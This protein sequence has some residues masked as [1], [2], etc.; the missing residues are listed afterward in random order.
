MEVPL[1]GAWESGL[2]TC[3]GLCLIVIFEMRFFLKMMVFL[4]PILAPSGLVADETIY[5]WGALDSEK[6][7]RAV[8]EKE[9]PKLEFGFYHWS[10]SWLIGVLEDFDQDRILLLLPSYGFGAGKILRNGEELVLPLTQPV[11]VKVAGALFSPEGM[12][13]SVEDAI[14]HRLGY[15]IAL[16]ATDRLSISAETFSPSEGQFQATYD[17]GRG[18]GSSFDWKGKRAPERRADAYEI[19]RKSLVKRVTGVLAQQE[20][21]L[22]R[23]EDGGEMTATRFSKA[24]D[25][26]ALTVRLEVS[27]KVVLIGES[28]VR[29]KLVG[30]EVGGRLEL[31]IAVANVAGVLSQV[32]MEVTDETDDGIFRA[33][34]KAA[35]GAG[36]V[37]VEI[38]EGE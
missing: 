21:C 29:E 17:P 2:L 11:T 7:Y 38:L 14:D 23:F 13:E 22:I 3:Y 37:R 27:D 24:G 28:G 12:T 10:G 26:D 32:V 20:K 19:S 1:W 33:A 4:A 36:L 31:A 16:E 6:G 35:R 5:P 18:W 25:G 30:R 15:W 8:V 34:L 9:F